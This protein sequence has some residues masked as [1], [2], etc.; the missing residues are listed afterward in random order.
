MTW[1]AINV[2]TSADMQDTSFTTADQGYAL[3]Q[4]GGLFRTA[5]GGASWQPIDP[6]TTSAPRGVITAGDVVLL[7]GPRGVRRASGGGEFT[8]SAAKAARNASV[9]QFDRGGSAIFAYGSTTIIRTTDRGRTW[10][11]IKGPSRKQGRRTV[12]LRLRDVDMASANGGYALDTS[13]RAWRTTNGGK[14]WNE[15]PAIGTDSGL[16]LAFGS[17]KWAT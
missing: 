12:A 16:A 7:A 8:L 3:D 2:A 4:R 14:R 13:G 1:K 15:L 5:N 17:A 6:G 9:D 11:A 10:K